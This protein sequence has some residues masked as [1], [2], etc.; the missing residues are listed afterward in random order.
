M[1]W[2][3]WASVALVAAGA[4]A[5]LFLSEYYVTLLNY[6]G[7]YTIVTVGMV[8]V[9]GIAGLT[10]LGHAALVGIAAYATAVLTT[11]HGLSPWITLPISLAVTAGAALFIGALTLRLSGHY[12]VLGTIA[13]G[14]S[15]Y[16]VFGN[17]S[18]L[19]GFNGITGI[20]PLALGSLVLDSGRTYYY[21]IWIVALLAM[22]SVSNV[23]DSRPGRAVRVIS[24]PTLAEAFG[25]DSSRLKIIIFVYSALLAGFAG[26]LQAHY[27]R[28]V[29]P[30]P[31]GVNASIEYL[32][33]IVIGGASYVGG[34]LVGA[35]IV[36][37]LKSLL[38]DLIPKLVGSAGQFEVIVFGLLVV[39]L[40]H[41]ASGGVMPRI[42]Q[43]LGRRGTPVIPA[44]AEPLP[45]R[46]R[47]AAGEL[48]LEV[49]CLSKS[50]GGLRAVS[51]V[52]FS[53]HS[54]EI[55]GLIGPN[56]A[57]KTTLF[58]VVTGVLP[59][60]SGQVRFRG[61]RIDGLP[62]R[63]IVALGIARTF[64]LVQLHAHM[65][66][67]E[68]AALGAHA[69]GH[70]GILSAALRLDRDEES[71]LLCEAR[72]QLERVGL[73]SRLDDLAGNLPLG[74]QRIVEIARALAADPILMLLD[75]P[76]A[77]LRYH[78]KQTLASLLRSLRAAGVSILLVEHDMELVMG[79]ADRL[80]VMDFGQKISEGAPQSV[81]RD[82][83]VVEAYLGT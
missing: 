75:E 17:V 47:P 40:L 13:W 69:R 49:E 46:S 74:Q 76:G 9:T 62:S 39:V 73:G 20:P 55:L 70:R 8:L 14:I 83:L 57:G 11:A 23:L 78:E 37:F 36:T 25:V 79:L 45:R 28:F 27:L 12:F 15:L 68:N 34:A 71:R 2:P 53:L 18:A 16:I 21:V 80:V 81:Q 29:N 72:K 66:L 38:Q 43:L 58:N 59:L 6:I 54:G 48:L 51:D 4:C 31:F 3:R 63:K 61:A 41:R 26:W 60:T 1:R 35:G 33:M 7:L 82:P 64:Q 10:S 22:L 50:F 19:G 56:G 30:G 52:S 24:R 32:F 65:S 44:D 67:A 42:A 5:P 77:G